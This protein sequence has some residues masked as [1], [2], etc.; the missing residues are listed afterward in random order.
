M[1]FCLLQEIRKKKKNIDKNIS[2]SLSSK[3][4]QKLL[5]LAKRCTTDTLNFSK[6]SDLK[7]S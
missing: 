1:D 2:K 4:S 5:D 3:C 6:K 7:S